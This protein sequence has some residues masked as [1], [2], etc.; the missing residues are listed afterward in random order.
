M[1]F[2]RRMRVG[3]PLRQ[4]DLRRRAVGYFGDVAGVG[5]AVGDPHGGGVGL[6]L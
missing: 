3:L 4:W 5:G 2:L 1:G 6:L